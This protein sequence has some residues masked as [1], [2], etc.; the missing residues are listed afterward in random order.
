M[1]TNS[2]TMKRASSQLVDNHTLRSVRPGT[3]RPVCQRRHSGQSHNEKIG[4]PS[5]RRSRTFAA[6][7]AT[8]PVVEITP[9][10]IVKRRFMSWR[11]TAAEVVQTTSQE[12]IEYRFQ[13]RMHMLAMC[14]QGARHDGETFLEG[15]PRS[16]L[17]DTSRKL[18]F[19]PA[20]HD[21]YEWQ[22]PRALTR[23]TYFY[24]DG[25]DLAVQSEMGDVETSLAPRL[26]FEDP[27]IRDTALKLKRLVES[28]TADDQLYV[29]ALGAVLVHELARL[30]RG[31]NR[32]EQPIRGGLAAWQQRIVTAYIEEHL[33][34]P[35]SLSLLAGIVRLSPYYFC[36][37]FK[38]SFGLPPHRYHTSRRIEH[39]KTLLAKPSSSVTDIGLTVGF[40]AT[41][42]FTAAFRR[43]TSLTPT[44]YR[45]SLT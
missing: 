11:R 8:H 42:S 27:A 43:G 14:D 29:E 40:S 3:L 16:T 37:A 18:V 1:L 23:V 20:G 33:A 24:F 30:N 28:P 32:I 13:G 17:R 7:D 26:Y 44:A 5:G 35:I 45:R 25:A 2:L 36:R 6:P 34:E 39:A 19:V 31:N 38:Q 10:D 4:S 41:S 22:E 15:L 21:Y 12:R 9:S